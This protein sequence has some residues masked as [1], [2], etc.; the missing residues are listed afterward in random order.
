MPYIRVLDASITCVQEDVASKRD[1]QQT[2]WTQ[3]SSLIP[4]YCSFEQYELKITLFDMVFVNTMHTF[5]NFVAEDFGN[6]SRKTFRSCTTDVPVA[7]IRRSCQ[8]MFQKSK[9]ALTAYSFAASLRVNK[10]SHL[11]V[12]L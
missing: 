5:W 7:G 4:A 12:S 8:R 9:L 3:M 2:V 11:A 6:F 10:E 1:D